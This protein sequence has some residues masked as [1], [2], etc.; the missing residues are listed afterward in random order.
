VLLCAAAQQQAMHERE[1]CACERKTKKREREKD[2]ACV[3]E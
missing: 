3:R 2:Q 1:S